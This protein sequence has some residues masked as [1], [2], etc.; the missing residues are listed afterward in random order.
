LA[1]SG[2]VQLFDFA[3]D[4]DSGDIHERVEI[5]ALGEIVADG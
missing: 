1:D 2:L 4:V 3:E 5:G